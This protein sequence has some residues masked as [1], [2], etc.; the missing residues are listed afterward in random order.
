MSGNSDLLTVNRLTAQ[1]YLTIAR[2]RG[3]ETGE[4][5]ED[6]VE[7]THSDWRA[8][9]S[10]GFDDQHRYGTRASAPHAAPCLPE[11]PVGSAM[12][13]FRDDML[14]YTRSCQW[15]QDGCGSRHAA[16]SRGHLR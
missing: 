8:C 2:T 13:M 1:S 16:L 12:N 7:A 3:K 14:L 5:A 9:D 15:W 6:S 11:M 4:A 10:L